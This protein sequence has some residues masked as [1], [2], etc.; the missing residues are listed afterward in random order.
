MGEAMSDHD[1]SLRALSTEFSRQAM[2]LE[3]EAYTTDLRGRAQRIAERYCLRA[4][5]RW[6]IQM[7]P[8]V[9]WNEEQGRLLLGA[10]PEGP[11]D[12][13]MLSALMIKEGISPC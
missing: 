7:T 6:G 5:E 11:L 1:L 12:E 13:A 10:E 3:R 4:R 2:F 8:I 9:R